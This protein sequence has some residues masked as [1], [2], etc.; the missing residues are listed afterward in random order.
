[1]QMLHVKDLG[2][3]RGLKSK[4]RQRGAGATENR[5]MITQITL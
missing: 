5:Q 2:R 1:L 4:K 3:Y